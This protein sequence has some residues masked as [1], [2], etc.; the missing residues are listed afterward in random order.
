RALRPVL[1]RAAWWST[2][3]AAV[4]FLPLV[5]TVAYKQFNLLALGLAFAGFLL[6]RRGREEAGGAVIA[7]SI[8]LKPVAILLVPSLLARR[9]T[10]RAGWHAVL[11]IAALT[12]AAQGFL[13][14]RAGDP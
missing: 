12:A 2:L 7:G 6:V 1:P 5:S 14:L 13:A 10:R 8:C 9:D 4:F 3:A 11:W